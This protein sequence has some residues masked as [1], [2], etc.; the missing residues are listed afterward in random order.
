MRA[1]RDNLFGLIMSE[2]E[3]ESGTESPEASGEFEPFRSYLQVLAE[4]QLHNRLKSKVDASD[5]VQQTML[6][7]YQ[8]KQQFRGS[9]DAEKAGWLRTILGNV[10]CGLA[11]DF[12]RQRRDVAREQ[13]IQA[14]E[15]SSLQLANLLSA[16]GSSPSAAVHRHERAN[17]L[18]QAML[19]LTHDQRQAIILKYWHSATLAEIGQ[20]LDKSPEAVAGLIF[21]GTQKLKGE[22]ADE[23]VD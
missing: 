1:F 17:V 3:A 5:V 14:V 15:Q 4:T 11:R 10:L 20:Q 13:S 19:K 12:S 8:A 18:A 2:S 22:Y 7:A 6:Q 9:S 23:S 21:R 16:D